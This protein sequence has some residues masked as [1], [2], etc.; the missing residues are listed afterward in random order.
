MEYTFVVVSTLAILPFRFIG[1]NAIFH[2]FV[3]PLKTVSVSPSRHQGKMS[4]GLINTATESDTK[5]L[6]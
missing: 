3:Q 1:I 2:F 6:R 4:G 5:A